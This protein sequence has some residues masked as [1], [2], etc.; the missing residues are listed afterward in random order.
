[1]HRERHRLP[2][3]WPETP[4]AIVLVEP[5]IPPNTGAIARLCAATD[6]VLHLVEPLG[7]R[8]T[9][10]MLKRAGLDYWDSV[11]LVRHH[12]LEEFRRDTAGR[13]KF[14]FSTS[15]RRN[16]T[17]I[18][19]EAGDMLL[20]GSETAGLPS[21]LLAEERESVYGIPM[22]NDNVRSLNLATSTAIV[23]YEALRQY[24]ASE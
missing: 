18:G 9:D 11:E 3:A 19:Y 21:D 17:E 10:H 22:R 8:L 6:S 2:Q 1:M 14:Y 23:L 13:R 7:F 5:Q 20:F 15:A 16:Y 4:L 12:S 24:N